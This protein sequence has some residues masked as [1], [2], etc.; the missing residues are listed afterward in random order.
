M[1]KKEKEQ[2]V[3]FKDKVYKVSDLSEEQITTVNQIADLERKMSQAQFNLS[4][5]EGG[6]QF[7]KEKLEATLSDANA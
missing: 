3:T 2:T 5:L 7:F 6:H 4:Q 1:S